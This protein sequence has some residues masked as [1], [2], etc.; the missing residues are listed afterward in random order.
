LEEFLRE[1]EMSTLKN[2]ERRGPKKEIMDAYIAVQNA[3]R[4]TENLAGLA[5]N[6]M[7]FW[8]PGYEKRKWVGKETL[9]INHGR[10]V[11]E[12]IDVHG[13]EIF[14]D[15]YFNADPHPGNMLLLDQKTGS[16]R[17]GLIDYGQVK[18]V[19]L[20]KKRSDERS[21]N[22]ATAAY[23]PALYLTDLS[24]ASLATPVLVASLFAAD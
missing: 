10:M 15:G 5:K 6:A 2:G 18:E 12:L 24:L 19:R 22:E 20:D 4:R 23:H 17:I 7:W 1:E 13:H 8:W 3:K 11:D 21:R 16:P 14:V 9:P